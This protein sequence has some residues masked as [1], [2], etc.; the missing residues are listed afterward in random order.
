MLPIEANAAHNDENVDVE[1]L[2]N[3]SS[4]PLPLYVPPRKIQK[5][6]YF[7]P[8]LRE[9][10]AISLHES[11]CG[12]PLFEPIHYTEIIPLKFYFSE[13]ELISL[14]NFLRRHIE[15]NIDFLWSFREYVAL[16][17]SGNP[18]PFNFVR[19][20]QAPRPF[21]AFHTHGLFELISKAKSQHRLTPK[22]DLYNESHATHSFKMGKV[23]F[24]MIL[25]YGCR[26]LP[27]FPNPRV[28]RN[29][30]PRLYL[31]Y[32]LYYHGSPYRGSPYFINLFKRTV[33]VCV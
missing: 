17:A 9:F 15:R 27:Y 33:C 5:H 6:D 8:S 4:S 29:I 13:I 7:V 1:I 25:H 24:Q 26:G 11:T 12:H 30:Q 18:D 2:S 3:P 22:I 32:T 21:G 31:D 16:V 20:P 28:W 23:L 19:I 10:S 14:H